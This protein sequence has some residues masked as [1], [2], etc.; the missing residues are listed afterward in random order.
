MCEKYEIWNF[1]EN[2]TNGSPDRYENELCSP[3]KVPLIIGRSQPNLHCGVCVDIARCSV[4]GKSLQW[5]LKYRRIAFVFPQFSALNHWLTVN[6][7]LCMKCLRARCE[8]HF[9]KIATMEAIIRVKVFC[10]DPKYLA[11]HKF[12]M[13][14]H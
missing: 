1:Q 11:E 5:R 10:L 3:S 6:N 12:W 13:S 2:H 9:I 14:W 8:R 4:S 7:F